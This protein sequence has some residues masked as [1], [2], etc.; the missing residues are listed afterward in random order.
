VI[1]G[2]NG[3][4]IITITGDTLTG[5]TAFTVNG[6]VSDGSDFQIDIAATVHGGDGDDLYAAND[7]G[8]VNR[9]WAGEVA[10]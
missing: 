2:T 10:A 8:L 4:D 5:N 9:R 7:N 1:S 3:A 6:V